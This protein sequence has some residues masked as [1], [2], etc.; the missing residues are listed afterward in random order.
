M[1][2]RTILLVDDEPSVLGFASL[3]LQQAGYNVLTAQN[4]V[5]GL[6][7]FIKSKDRISCVVTDVQMPQMDGINMA[8]AI[9]SE[10]PDLKVV[11]ISGYAP[12]QELASLVEDWSA[13]YLTKPFTIE[14][15]AAAIP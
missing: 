9:H 7:E 8:K 4:G 11:F 2:P 1:N 14:S 10:N 3:V 6:N 13:T 12:T 5:D 15:L